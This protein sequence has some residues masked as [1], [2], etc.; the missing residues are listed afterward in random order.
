[1]PMRSASTTPIPIVAVTEVVSTAGPQHND[2]DEIP[3]ISPK[4][5]V[6]KTISTID[7]LNTTNGD[8]NVKSE[9]VEI[10]TQSLK[11]ILIGR[12]DGHYL[13]VK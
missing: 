3:E 8:G 2:D 9:K 1:M 5:T 12:H 4:M 11:T 6:D 10:S 7:A 13:S